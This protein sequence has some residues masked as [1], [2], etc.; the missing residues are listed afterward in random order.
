MREIKADK[1]RLNTTISKEFY[2]ELKVKA[3]YIGITVQQLLVSY[4]WEHFTQLETLNKIPT[5]LNQ[6]MDI[7]KVLPDAANK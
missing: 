3:D 1:V 6:M 4:A 5:M 7:T 2:E